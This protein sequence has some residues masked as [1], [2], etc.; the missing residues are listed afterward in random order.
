MGVAQSYYI[1]APRLKTW[2]S[3]GCFQKVVFTSLLVLTV[4]KVN[5]P[6]EQTKAFNMTVNKTQL[7]KIHM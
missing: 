1:V 7:L 2:F 6:I 5:C 3:L 4:S